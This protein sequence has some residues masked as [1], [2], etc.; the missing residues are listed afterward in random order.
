MALLCTCNQPS[1]IRENLFESRFKIVEELRKMGADIR[2]K[3]C[4]AYI[5][6][7]RPLYGKTL[8]AKDLRGGAALI[9]AGLVAEG[10]TVVEHVEHVERGY[11]NI[12]SDLSKLGANIQERK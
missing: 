2:V 10:T 1:F 9:L 5:G 3:D 7:Y 12:V 4:T 6:G 8:Y 11:Q